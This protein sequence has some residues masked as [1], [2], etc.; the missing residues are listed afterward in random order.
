M[1]MI[2]SRGVAG[3]DAGADDGAACARTIELASAAAVPASICRRVIVGRCNMKCNSPVES[4]NAMN[5][6]RQTLALVA[7][8]S[9]AAAAVLYAAEPT[10]KPEDLPRVPPTEP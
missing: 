1:S 4:R 7:L 10:V 9:I 6:L 8:L 5:L 2:G 3:C